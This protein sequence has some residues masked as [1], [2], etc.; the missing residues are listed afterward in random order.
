MF[1]EGEVPHDLGELEDVARLHLVAVVLEAAVPVLRHLGRPARE[2]LDDLVD[3]SLV[4]DRSQSD[5]L[6]VLA[7]HVH[8]HVVVE[9]LDRE[10]L[11]RLAQNLALF[12]PH[13]CACAVVRI[14]HLVADVEQEGLPDVGIRRLHEKVPAASSCRRSGHMI[15]RS[16]QAINGTATEEPTYAA[17]SS[18]RS[19]V[20]RPALSAARSVSARGDA[21]ESTCAGCPVGATTVD[22]PEL[23]ALLEPPLGLRRPDAGGR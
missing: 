5:P 1:A 18:T 12:L 13:D 21:G 14:H 11:A 19:L 4:D 20:S 23:R 3:R 6:R 9:D 8:G 22:D 17:A 7:R 15:A 16:S 2:R 10:V